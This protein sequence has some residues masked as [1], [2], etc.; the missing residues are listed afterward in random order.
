MAKIWRIGG[1]EITTPGDIPDGA[2]LATGWRLPSA[3]LLAS[4][5]QSRI[6]A[7]D[8]FR[9]LGGFAGGNPDIQ[10]RDVQWK[11]FERLNQALLRG[12]I[13]AIHRSA[14]GSVT[15]SGSG[16]G[17]Q[18]Q[19][20]KQKPSSQSAF[21][22]T[23]ALNSP[24]SEKTWVDIQLLDEDGDPVAGERYTLKLTDGSTREGSLGDDGRVRVNGIDPGTCVVTFPDIDTK[25]WKRKS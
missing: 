19:T 24:N 15:E 9:F 22:A 1:R 10:K 25:E 3:G 6:D 2:K 18:N 17:Q 7:L 21:S 14:E 16:G 23:G 11:I 20:P 12:Q 4:D 5:S 8:L 13:V